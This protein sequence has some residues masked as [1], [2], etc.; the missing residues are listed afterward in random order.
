[1]KA[2][3]WLQGIS[4]RFECVRAAEIRS[5]TWSKIKSAIMYVQ[6]ANG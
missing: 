4:Q 2:Y 1:M 3:A 6:G 5:H